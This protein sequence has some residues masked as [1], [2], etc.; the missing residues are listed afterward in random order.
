MS[1]RKGNLNQIS[2]F[3]AFAFLPNAILT[4]HKV[5]KRSYSYKQVLPAMNQCGLPV[6]ICISI[7]GRDMRPER[8][9]FQDFTYRVSFS[10]CNGVVFTVPVKPL[11]KFMLQGLHSR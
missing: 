8:L 6:L 3:Y 4:L 7:K 9:D 1:S 11:I 10:L 2:Y 5:K